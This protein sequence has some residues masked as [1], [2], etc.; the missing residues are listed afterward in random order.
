MV[1]F[2]K[3]ISFGKSSYVISLPKNWIDKNKLVKGSLISVREDVENLILS[4]KIDEDKK[5]SK[6]ITINVDGK[7]FS[8]M[9]REII[10][11]YVN[12]YHTINII[13]K[14]LK[15]KAPQVRDILHNLMAL[16]IMEQ[17]SDKIIA[18]D[19]V[20]MD[21][22]N[23]INLI[24]KM[25]VMTRAML[26]DLD[27][28]SDI[29]Y[30]NIAHR[31]EDVNRMFFLL[32]RATKYALNNP[33]MMREYKTTPS[34]LLKTWNIISSIEKTSDEIKR[35][36]RYSQNVKLQK[37]M[38][39]EL[40]RIVLEIR[41]AFTTIMKAFYNSDR[42]LAYKVAKLKKQTLKTC[43]NF[44]AKYW[45]KE[46]VPSIVEKF[47]NIVIEIHSVTRNVYY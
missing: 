6:S 45:K 4:P 17:T 35:V 12:N 36:A 39:M 46:F 26:E 44:Y 11:A 28:N 15:E 7:S 27:F 14:E 34:E 9:R 47:K 32:F 3:L 40:N 1:D 10:P 18:R 31:D 22:I 20:N 8:Q 5:E 30:E 37:D 19:F 33:V 41:N 43:D 16:E 23:M 29:P 21:K 42:D 25:D 38:K 2:R 13:G 24:R